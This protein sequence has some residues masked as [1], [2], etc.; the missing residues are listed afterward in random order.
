VV[1]A[2]ANGASRVIAVEIN[3]AAIEAIGGKYRKFLGLPPPDSGRLRIIHG[4]GRTYVRGFE[5]RF[6]VIQMTGADTFAAGTVSGSLLSESYLYTQE[7]MADLLRA[8]K[9]DGLLAITRF[10]PEG[11]RVL[12]I[13]ARA[14]EW[15]GS[16]DP[17]RHIVVVRQ[18]LA[19]TTL[20]IKKE[21]YDRSDVAAVRALCRSGA[22]HA[23]HLG[24]PALKS[25]GYGFDS[26][27]LP[28]YY[29][30]M[31]EDIANRRVDRRVHQTHAFYSGYYSLLWAMKHDTMNDWLAKADFDYSPPTD[32]KPF[33]FHF[34]RVRWPTLEEMFMAKKVPDYGPWDLR[35]YI[36]LILQVAFVS[37]LL[38]LGP[39][40]ILRRRGQALGSAPLL[41][42]YFFAVG[43]GFMLIE[44]G[45]M[46]KL[47][48]FLGHPNYSI[49]TVLFS[50]LVFSGLGSL[51]S[52]HIKLSTRGI[53]RLASAA[54]VLAV[55]SFVPLSFILLDSSRHLG[56]G[57]RIALATG[58]L[59]PL[60]FFMGM[61]FPVFLRRTEQLNPRFTPWAIGINGFA[62]VLGSLA[63]IPLTITIGFT[64]TLFVG[65]AAY[66]AA[67]L[68][69]ECRSW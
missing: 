31:F 11:L 66:A 48:L 47:T 40:F 26:P 57:M 5:N 30:G 23:R 6:D 16:D 65:A 32:D 7:S 52:H 44:I 21:P 54:V 50:L 3:R 60:S 34:A 35:Q 46:Q 13:A 55:V 63:A 45:M 51:A 64:A 41:A 42:I 22:R 17:T 9:P 67:W 43:V 10:G 49:S 36:G 56:I 12:T 18:G 8:L 27:M 2:L 39:L 33:F 25:I 68:V 29:P 37:L 58:A 38:I 28:V 53:I 1:A 59:S 15:A 62:S 20:L 24:Q 4:D 19:W 61:F 69:V 14:L